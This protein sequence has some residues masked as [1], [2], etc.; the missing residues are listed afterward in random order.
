MITL[1][2]PKCD[3]PIELFD[4]KDAAG[5]LGVSE[6]TIRRACQQH[7]IG[8]QIAAAWILTAQ[9]VERLRHVVRESAGN[10]NFVEGNYFGAPPPNNRSREP[11]RRKRGA[12]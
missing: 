2:C 8:Q 1:K 6:R 9:D 5:Q 11:K 10:P 7:D 3:A 4:G 12:Q